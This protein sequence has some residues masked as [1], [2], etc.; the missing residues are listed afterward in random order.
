MESYHEEQFTEEKG[1]D[2]TTWTWLFEPRQ[3]VRKKDWRM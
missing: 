3:G 2:I 1:H